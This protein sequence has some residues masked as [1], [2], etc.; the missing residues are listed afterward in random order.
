MGTYADKLRKLFFW[1]PGSQKNLSHPVMHPSNT[2][3]E[4]VL[5][6]NVDGY[7]LIHV[8]ASPETI[9]NNSFYSVAN[10]LKYKDAGGTVHTIGTTDIGGLVYKGALDCAANPNYPA[11]TSGDIYIVSVAGKVGGG[12][13][14]A[15]EVGDMLV[16]KTTGVAGTKAAVGANWDIVQAGYKSTSTDGTFGDNSDDLIPTQKAAKTYSDGKIPKV[17]A[18]VENNITTFDAAGV[19]KDSGKAFSTDGTL[20]GN[21]DLLSP[22]EKA[23][24]TYVDARIGAI[25]EGTPVNAV[26]ARGTLTVTGGGNQIANDYVVLVDEKEYTFKTVLTPAEGE[27]LIGANDTA[28]LLNLKNAINHT[29]TPGTDYSC[30]AAHPTVEGISSDATTLIVAARTKGVAG[31]N[32]DVGVTGAEIS[33]DDAKLG[34]TVAG[35]DGTEGANNELAADGTYLYICIAT[36]T[37]ADANWRRIAVASVF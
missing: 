25:P 18:A 37:I 29:G 14:D 13:G 28:A 3:C 11:A 22:T 23:I 5:G 7:H 6:L 33:W 15:V 8:Y 31:N 27:V 12:S 2:D 9:P 34:T 17:G 20:A 32:I 26:A 21:S 19:V 30:A 1:L 36:N 16:C 35:V 24:K 10:V 4:A